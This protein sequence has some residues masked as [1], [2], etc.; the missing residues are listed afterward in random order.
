MSETTSCELSEAVTEKGPV[1]L[2]R[3]RR[4][5]QATMLVVLGQ[6][7]FYG[8]FRCPFIVPY[9]SCQNCPVVT[10]HG[11]L[12]SLFWGFWL[13]LPVSVLLFG[14]AYC[15]WLC[16]GGLVNQLFAQT[17]PFS[18]RLKNRLTTLA[19]YGKYL[20]LAVALYVWLGMGQP[21][22]N[23]PIRVGEFFG[24]VALTFEHADLS[25]LV[26]TSVVLGLTALGLIFANAWCRYFCPAGGL[27]EAVKGIAFFK[28]YKT[29]S[30]NDCDKCRKVCPMGTRPG[31]VDCTNCGDCLPVC[32]VDAI[33]IGR[34]K[35]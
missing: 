32:S 3:W 8:I 18:L 15:G 17:A 35:A 11:R 5:S 12:F 25:W 21:R 6:W 7:S 16:P 27:L 10:C 29:H 31:E 20:T 13:L 22:T 9:V 2:T 4:L 23:I 19:P 26:R 1:A 33:G 24:A 30:C 14:R 34:G 28:V